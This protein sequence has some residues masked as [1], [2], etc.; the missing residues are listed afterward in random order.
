MEG[1]LEQIDPGEMQAPYPVGSDNPH[2]ID[3]PVA[4]FEGRDLK[5]TLQGLLVWLE[6]DQPFS[7]DLVSG[8]QVVADHLGRHNNRIAISQELYG[9]DVMVKMAMSKANHFC[10]SE[11]FGIG[12]L[13]P[14]HLPEKG[15]KQKVTAGGFDHERRPPEIFYL[16]FGNHQFPPTVGF[17]KTIDKSL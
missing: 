11:V 15:V 10:S 12:I 4:P 1:N 14:I 9:I 17:D 13:C 16:W 5:I 6:R 2:E 8:M 3:H 7:G